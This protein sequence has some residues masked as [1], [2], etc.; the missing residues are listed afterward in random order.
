MQWVVG[1]H[2]GKWKQSIIDCPVM[3]K[4]KVFTML[5]DTEMGLVAARSGD[6][7]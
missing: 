3:L 1:I 4:V 7:G 6:G 2:S 5:M